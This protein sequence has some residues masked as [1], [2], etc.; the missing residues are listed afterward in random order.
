MDKVFYEIRGGYVDATDSCSSSFVNRKRCPV[1]DQCRSGMLVC[2]GT[3]FERDPS[4]PALW[5]RLELREKHGGESR[6]LAGRRTLICSGDAN[7]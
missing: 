2:T 7:L 3:A 1:Y 6:D 5:D 4:G